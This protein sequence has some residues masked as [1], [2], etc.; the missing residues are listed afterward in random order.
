M[1][2]YTY[3]KTDAIVYTEVPAFLKSKDSV[4]YYK[5][6]NE[7]LN[8]IL[9]NDQKVQERVYLTKLKDTD[10]T[11]HDILSIEESFKKYG[12]SNNISHTVFVVDSD[13]AYG[14][15]R[16]IKSGIERLLHN[17]SIERIDSAIKKHLPEHVEDYII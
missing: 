2:T 13:F 9:D 3:D 11:Y 4:D 5:R 17:I 1:I 12:H 14:I 7:E 10:I 15:A 16:M 6:I 8:Q